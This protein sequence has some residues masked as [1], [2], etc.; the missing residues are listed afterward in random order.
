MRNGLIDDAPD[1]LHLFIERLYLGLYLFHAVVW[2]K[3]I[4]WHGE[5]IYHLA[6]LNDDHA[7]LN[8][9]EPVGSHHH[10]VFA[11]PDYQRVACVPDDRR[12]HRALLDA[13]AAYE[14]LT[15][16]FLVVTVDDRR[17][18]YVGC[19]VLFQIV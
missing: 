18:D 1:L 5:F 12:C 7:S 19:Q 8:I 16:F 9:D 17:R 11:A 3:A 14:A 2:Y 13:G 15:H 4:G 10:I 6:V